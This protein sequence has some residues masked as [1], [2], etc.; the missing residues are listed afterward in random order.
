[1]SYRRTKFQMSVGNDGLDG[2]SI[3]FFAGATQQKR[4]HA[5]TQKPCANCL[6]GDTGGS[7]IELSSSSSS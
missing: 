4:V 2:L 3:C 1:M 5:T 6:T 7:G